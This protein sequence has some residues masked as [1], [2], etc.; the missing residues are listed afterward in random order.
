MSRLHTIY[1][2]GM[3]STKN[4]FIH[5]GQRRH[6]PPKQSYICVLLFCVT[7]QK[8]LVSITHTAFV[9]SHSKGLW[10]RM[11]TVY[12][13]FLFNCAVYTS[14]RGPA[15]ERSLWH[16]TH[17]AR[18]T[19]EW[20]ITQDVKNSYILFINIIILWRTR[21]IIIII[22]ILRGKKTIGTCSSEDYI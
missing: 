22:V 11:R 2:K 17:T 5:W 4:T 15:P 8:T 20:M 3:N 1:K 16:P 12:N 10:Y 14:D 9:H 13:T 19:L 6:V 21:E 18:K 7:S